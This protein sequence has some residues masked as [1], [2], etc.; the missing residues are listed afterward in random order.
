MGL[1]YKTA[2]RA[3]CDTMALSNVRFIAAA[4]P[5]LVIVLARQE[6]SPDYRVVLIGLLSGVCSFVYLWSMIRA[7]EREPLSTSWTII[8]LGIVMP[9][10]ASIIFWGEQ[11]N[12]RLAVGFALALVSLV[13]LGGGGGTGEPE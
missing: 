4:L 8:G 9:V 2:S 5:P 12:L 10:A 1:L 11:F 13:L 6:F 7:L 3:R